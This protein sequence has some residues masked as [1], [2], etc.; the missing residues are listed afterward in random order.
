[1]HQGWIEDKIINVPFI[2]HSGPREVSLFLLFR[3]VERSFSFTGIGIRRPVVASDVA[4]LTLSAHAVTR[5]GKDAW[6]VSGESL[7]RRELRGSTSSPSSRFSQA[8][9]FPVFSFAKETGTF[10]PR[11]RAGGSGNGA[12]SLPP[13]ISPAREDRIRDLACDSL[14]VPG[15]TFRSRAK[16]GSRSFPGPPPEPVV[17]LVL[18]TEKGEK[19]DSFQK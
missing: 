7:I 6:V 17:G 12:F 5:S 3:I 19:T 10:S 11:A 1:M 9:L 18:P 15:R 13:A 16:R 4:Y 14:S 8:K 2:Y